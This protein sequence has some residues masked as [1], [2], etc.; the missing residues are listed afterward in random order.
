MFYLVGDLAVIEWG[1]GK[2]GIGRSIIV[3]RAPCP[4]FHGSSIMSDFLPPCKFSLFFCNITHCVTQINF[5]F[6]IRG[7][8]SRYS[9]I[10]LPEKLFGINGHIITSSQIN[11]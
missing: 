9:H 11:L 6:L 10:F 1:R 3:D 7:L 2:E 4:C 8:L 5:F